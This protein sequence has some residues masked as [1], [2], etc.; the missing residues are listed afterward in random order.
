MKTPQ[1]IL[2]TGGAGFIGVHTVGRLDLRPGRRPANCGANRTEAAVALWSGEAGRG[3]LPRNV[4]AD[5]RPAGTGTPLFECL[6]PLPGW[7]RRGR[8]GGH[9]LRAD[10]VRS[11]P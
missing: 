9:H 4:F 6:R 8:C 5:L 10:D 7:D 11:R 2:V 1:R 3:E